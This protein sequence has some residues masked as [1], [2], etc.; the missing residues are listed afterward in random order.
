MIEKKKI[1]ISLVQNIKSVRDQSK[2]SYITADHLRIRTLD[3][4]L[5]LLFRTVYD[6]VALI[7]FVSGMGRP[8]MSDIEGTKDF[9]HLCVVGGGSGGSGGKGGGGG[10]SDPPGGCVVLWWLALVIIGEFT[11]EKM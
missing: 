9:I 3:P 11:V 10:R 8:L 5:V 2:R 7:L 1:N 4:P 6:T